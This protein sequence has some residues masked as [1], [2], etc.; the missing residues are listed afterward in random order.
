MKISKQQSLKQIYGVLPI[1]GE[2][3]RLKTTNKL[4]CG[5]TT[6]LAKNV[7]LVGKVSEHTPNRIRFK[8]C[9][10]TFEQMK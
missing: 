1:W 7:Q 8:K 2:V 5:T 3:R 9:S 10:Q 6:C 4:C